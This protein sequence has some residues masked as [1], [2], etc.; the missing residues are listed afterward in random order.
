MA[1]QGIHKPRVTGSSPVAATFRTPRNRG[2]FSFPNLCIPAV[3]ACPPPHWPDRALIRLRRTFGCRFSAIWVALR[4][5]SVNSGSSI[6]PRGDGAWMEPSSVKQPV[7]Q[8]PT[9][10]LPSIFWHRG[11]NQF[12]SKIGYK[13]VTRDGRAERI[14]RLPAARQGQA[15]GH[16]QGVWTCWPLRHWTVAHFKTT[17]V[18]WKNPNRPADAVAVSSTSWTVCPRDNWMPPRPLYSIMA[19]TS[20]ARTRQENSTRA[21]TRTSARKARPPRHTPPAT[22][23]SEG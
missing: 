16:A 14:P 20:P 21:A 8:R 3:Y 18:Q 1:E 7:R 2:A 10:R 23:W 15:G 12:V 4:A 13:R 11:A 5:A 19:R 9:S 22:A 17:S 6:R